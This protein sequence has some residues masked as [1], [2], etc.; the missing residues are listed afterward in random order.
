MAIE[1]KRY[2]ARIFDRDGAALVRT[3]RN[4]EIRS[5]PVINDRI[6]GGMGECT[7]DLAAPFDDFG[8]GDEIDH[9]YILEIKCFD[10]AHPQGRVL[11]FGA[12]Q[13]YA[14]YIRGA[15]QGV[16]IKAIGVGSNLSYDAHMASSRASYTVAYAGV[17]PE[18]AFKD[19]IDEHNAYVNNPL[20]NYQPGSTQAVGVMVDL[21]F[22][23]KMWH[24]CIEE[25]KDACPPGWWWHVG[26]DRIAKLLPKPTTPTHLFIIGKHI[27][28]GMF[29]KSVKTLK[30]R[31]RI[32]RNGGS[33][34][35]YEDPASIALYESRLEIGG[36]DSLGDLTTSDQVGEKLLG[37]KSQPKDKNTLV[38]N[39]EYD[40]ESIEVGS[41]CC[42]L[43]SNEAATF[44][45]NAQIV[46][47][48]YEGTRV[49]LELEENT[50]DLGLALDRFV[51][52]A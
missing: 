22:T 3:I 42:I 19:I 25:T 33:T 35:I 28:E 43:N 7:L 6:N 20:L 18:D 52:A 16:L 34:E 29:T 15:M 8:E 24:D 11:F 26:A 10:S 36:D 45:T 12:I 47:L 4:S 51:K 2:M 37:D 5:A 21:T 23:D 50:V 13:E 27:E 49:R 48:T 30:N 44:V 31:I 40:L 39:A 41:T 32:A 38:I 46:G 17:D 14:P 1:V 9:Q